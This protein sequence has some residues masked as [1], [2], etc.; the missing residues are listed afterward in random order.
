[1]D[2]IQT[3]AFRVMTLFSPL[4]FCQMPDDQMIFPRSS[5]RFIFTQVYPVIIRRSIYSSHILFT[6]QEK[7][8]HHIVLLLCKFWV[9][10]MGSAAV[11]C[12]WEH[13]GLRALL[14]SSNGSLA[15]TPNLLVSTLVAELRPSPPHPNNCDMNMNYDSEFD[16]YKS[17]W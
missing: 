13:D 3:W 1:M 2:R 14:G 17:K 8:F 12:P 15:W 5:S 7:H 16:D 11:R 10:S 4:W 9:W 6:P